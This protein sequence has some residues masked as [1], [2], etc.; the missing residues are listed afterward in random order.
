MKYIDNEG[1]EKQPVMLHRVI[2]GSLERFLGALLEHYAAVFPLWL[3]PVQAMIIPVRKEDEPYAG[4][5]KERL[6]SS[7]LRVE[8]DLSNET[9]T[10]R[11]RNA[12]VEKHP[13]IIVVG[14]KEAKENKIA[15]RKRGLGDQGQIDLEEF[16]GKAK[17]EITNK[18]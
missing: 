5:V 2:L 1:K 7:G 16:I 4:Q 13:Y 6:T 3:A 17:T 15:L 12:E 9:L 18:Q 10:K 8:L 11:I 14:P